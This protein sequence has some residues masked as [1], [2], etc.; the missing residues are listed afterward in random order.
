[1]DIKAL[2][3]IS[4]G[5]YIVT[6]NYNNQKIG[7]VVNTVTQVTSEN[8]IISININKNNYTNEMITKSK[9]LVVSILS[10][11]ATQEL[12]SNF[13]YFSSKEKNKFEETKY[14]EIDNLPVINEGVCGYL[15]CD[16]IEKIDCKTLN[17]FLLIQFHVTSVLSSSIT[18]F[19]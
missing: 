19:A 9:K 8:P 14:E 1:M 10:E 13:G 5:M 12:I 15:I 16:L 3:D 17:V 4:Y 2:H 18:V 7:C 11:N 6:T